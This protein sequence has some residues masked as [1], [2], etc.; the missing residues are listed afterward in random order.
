MIAQTLNPAPLI[1]LPRT[2]PMPVPVS[3]FMKPALIALP[4]PANDTG[5]D[6]AG[7]A[8][9][10]RKRAARAARLAARAVG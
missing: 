4:A 2:L 10:L 8:H 3:P 6:K 7:R 9:I 5:P 1:A